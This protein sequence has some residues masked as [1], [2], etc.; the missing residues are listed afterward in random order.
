MST[1]RPAAPGADAEGIHPLDQPGQGTSPD[2]MNT[3]GIALDETVMVRLGLEVL[4]NNLPPD[5]ETGDLRG[6]LWHIHE[7]LCE[8][9]IIRLRKHGMTRR[10]L[11]IIPVSPMNPP[12]PEAMAQITAAIR[13]LDDHG[14][15]IG[16]GPAD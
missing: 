7:R 5:I 2:D 3:L 11:I 6:A 14:L 9:E 4:W 12:G 16:Y 10:Y 13:T 15:I 8:A 1:T